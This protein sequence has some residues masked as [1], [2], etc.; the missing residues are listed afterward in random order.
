MGF[1]VE[2][3]HREQM[4]CPKGVHHPLR[5]RNADP[6]SHTHDSHAALRHRRTSSK[7][8]RNINY[9]NSTQRA[10]KWIRGGKAHKVTCYIVCPID[11]RGGTPSIFSALFPLLLESALKM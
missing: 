8:Q 6:E 10:L 9:M 3:L 1:N 11:N 5:G 4:S 2:E 7:P